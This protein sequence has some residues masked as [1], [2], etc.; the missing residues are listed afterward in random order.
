MRRFRR[1][2]V[3]PVTAASEPPAAL[4]EAVTLAEGSGAE[5]RVLGHLDPLSEA[6]QRAA[7]AAGVGDLLDRVA[8]AVER[9]IT[10]WTAQVDGSPESVDV[11]V[12]SLPAVVAAAVNADG[13]DLVIVAADRSLESAA[14]S[15]RIVRAAPCPVWL[16]RPGFRGA[17]VFAALDLDADFEQNRLILDLARS[18]AETHGGR[19]RVM[20]AWQVTHLEELSR[21]DGPGL[22]PKVQAA[23]VDSVEG[24]H[25]ESLDQLLGPDVDRR[26]VHLVDGSPGRSV[27]ALADLYRADLVVM[28]AGEARAGSAELGPTAEQVLAEA[29]CSVLVVREQ[30]RAQTDM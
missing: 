13:H 24:A 5:V 26:D 30:G 15:R 17:C 14:A 7:D 27:L 23:I 28:G 4:T 22:D 10:E 25:R 8:S 2:L 20:H 19:L 21:G 9:R 16:L 6:E 3:V 1:I 18:Q 12:G 11:A 29:E